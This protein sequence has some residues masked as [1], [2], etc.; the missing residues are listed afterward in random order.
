[1]LIF[2]EIAHDVTLEGKDGQ[3][4]KVEANKALATLEITALHRK[5]DLWSDPNEFKPERWLDASEKRGDR[6]GGYC[7]F[8]AG[9]RICIGMN[10]S[11]LEQR[12]ALAM[13][14]RR[15]EWTLPADSPHKDGLKSHGLVVMKPNLMK[16]NIQRF[17]Q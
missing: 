2:R 5:P 13:L 7:P 10:F 12:V 8:G 4:H 14:L 6:R 9:P 1:M 15:Y 16:M 17:N 3:V 11:L